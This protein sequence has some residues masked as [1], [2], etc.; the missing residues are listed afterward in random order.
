MPRHSSVF[1]ACCI[2]DCNKNMIAR[3]MCSK[4]YYNWK[5]HDNPIS[6]KENHEARFWKCVD[7]TGNCWLWTGYTLDSGYGGLK[8]KS[9]FVLAHRYSWMIHKGTIPDNLFVLHSCDV[10]N[11][12][13]PDHLFLGT[14]LDNMKDRDNKG[15][16]AKHEKNGMAV[17]TSYQVKEIIRKYNDKLKPTSY[18]KLSKEYRVHYTQIARIVKRK[19]WV[20]I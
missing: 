3:G 18:R 13:N 10:R 5:R 9:K 19:H 8:V 2:D 17:L 4:H 11:C 16:Q 15:R 20:G 1:I 6:L 12:V 7:K 14:S